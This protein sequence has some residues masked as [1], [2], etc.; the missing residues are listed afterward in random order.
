M[1][2][3]AGAPGRELKRSDK[4]GG[5]AQSKTYL[6]NALT[7]LSQQYG[8]TLTRIND[9]NDITEAYLQNAKV[10]IF[11]NGNGTSGGSIPADSVKRRVEDFV[12]VRGWGMI[13][14][15]MACAF[16]TTWP[17]QE[18]ACVQQDIHHN[19]SGT[20]A[21]VHAENRI[22]GGV[23]HGRAN[24]YSSFFLAGLPDSVPMSDKWLT[25]SSTGT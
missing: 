5:N 1:E 23:G 13:M 3:G 22:V 14:I 6:F 8:F 4:S 16:I 7:R 20:P 10:I 12:Q 19:P 18:Q 2:P 25:W 24:P 21:T 15:H 11:S 9:L 17:F